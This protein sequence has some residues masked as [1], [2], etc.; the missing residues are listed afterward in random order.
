M[1]VEAMFLS[2]L[3][4]LSGCGVVVTALDGG[5]GE[6]ASSNRVYPDGAAAAD[7]ACDA[8]PVCPPIV[9]Q[10]GTCAAC[11]QLHL[12]ADDAGMLFCPYC[13]VQVL[14]GASA[15]RSGYCVDQPCCAGVYNGVCP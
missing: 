13:H 7:A 15:D 2:A 1:R 6:D 10:P 14:T 9:V 11:C 12:Q 5:G 4:I 8:D 3:S